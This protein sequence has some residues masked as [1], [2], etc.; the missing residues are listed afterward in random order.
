LY[1]H[2]IVSDSVAIRAIFNAIK[3]EREILKE[4]YKVDIFQENLK[5]KSIEELEELLEQLKN[6]ER[7]LLK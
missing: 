1:E 7:E 3:L 6:E 2:D 4:P 5:D